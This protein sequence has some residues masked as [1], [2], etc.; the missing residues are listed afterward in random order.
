VAICGTGDDGGEDDPRAGADV[1]ERLGAL[2]AAS[3]LRPDDAARDLSEA[4]DSRLRMLETIREFGLEQ[5]ELAG[6]TAAMRRQHALYYLAL[7]DGADPLLER[8]GASRWDCRL[9][10]DLDNVRAALG[11]CVEQ[12]GASDDAATELGLRAAGSL[13]LFWLR[14]GMSREGRSWLARLLAMPGAQ[15]RTLGR[16]RA[17]RS[18]GQVA[19]TLLPPGELCALY[20]ESLEIARGGSYR[21][22][23][24]L[25]LLSLGTEIQDTIARRAYLEE[26]LAIFNLLGD[27][28][29]LQ[30][31]H[32]LAIASM[33]EGDL[34]T[35]RNLLEQTLAGYQALGGTPW[36][37]VIATRYIGYCAQEQGNLHEAHAY[38]TRALEMGEGSPDVG[39]RASTVEFLGLL[40]LG[41]GETVRAVRLA[42]AAAGLCERV[43]HPPSRWALVRQTRIRTA[44]ERLL[45]PLARATAWA[46]GQAMTLEQAIAEAFETARVCE[47]RLAAGALTEDAR[48]AL[49]DIGAER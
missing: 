31:Q 41:V 4:D 48:P 10:A 46:E 15:E 8:A 16:A 18:S 12:G 1:L 37:I 9:D 26:A 28:Y 19:Q 36:Y 35:A 27:S 34:V 7:V 20:E 25:A 13:G 21:R 45:D 23:T 42:A 30:T 17:L 32:F 39:E 11:W 49:D 47:A 40:A 33:D 44:A 3:L 29:R 6:E 24:A 14:R 38:F 5:L 43:G 22:E 2:V